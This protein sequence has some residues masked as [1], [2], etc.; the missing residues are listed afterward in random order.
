MKV[1]VSMTTTL[2]RLLDGRAKLDEFGECRFEFGCAREHVLTLDGTIPL[3][4]TWT[5]PRQREGRGIRSPPESSTKF[6]RGS[7]GTAK[8][9]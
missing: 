4:A 8:T 9:A 3:E 7:G 2:L 5:N 1:A 6:G